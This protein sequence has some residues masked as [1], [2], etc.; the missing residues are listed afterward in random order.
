MGNLCVDGKCSVNELSELNFESRDLRKTKT[1]TKTG[2]LQPG[3]IFQ[4][5]LI[6][7]IECYNVES[8]CGKAA[9]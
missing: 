2:S 6:V 8:L 1:K 7:I 3:D 4:F 5:N 9:L